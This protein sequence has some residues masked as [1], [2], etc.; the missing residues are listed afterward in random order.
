MKKKKKKKYNCEP[1]KTIND[2]SFFTIETMPLSLKIRPFDILV[3]N[4]EKER[5]HTTVFHSVHLD[6]CDK[7]E[8]SNEM[9]SFNDGDRTA[10]RPAS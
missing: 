3:G 6:V 8:T 10:A 4:F 1:F 7:T 2:R 9:K 5:Y